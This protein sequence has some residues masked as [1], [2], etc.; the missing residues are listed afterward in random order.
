[1]TRRDLMQ[2]RMEQREERFARRG[3]GVVRP[4]AMGPEAVRRILRV[5]PE[6]AGMRLDRFVQT[7]LRA[8]SRARTQR[9]VNI[10][11]FTPD[12]VRLKNNHRV[13]AEERVVL[14]REAWDEPLPDAELPVVYEDAALLAINKP[15][16]VAVHPTARH[17]RGTVTSLLEQQRPDD[18]LTLLHR[19]DRETSGVL[20]LARTRAADRAVKVQ[21]EER[22]DVLK[23]YVAFAWG[24]PEWERL[25]CELP[26]ELD[27]G[28]R[29]RVKMRVARPGEGLVA[30]TTFEVL[31]RRT[32]AGRAYTM[33]RCTLHTGRQH[34]IRIHL[35]SLGLPVVGDKL[36]GPD[37]AMHRRAADMKLTAEDMARLELS[38]HALHAAE[39]ELDHP[40]DGRRLRIEAPLLDDMRAFWDALDARA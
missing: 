31:G 6:L 30:A 19:L 13:R 7:Q 10:G 32:R 4:E 3:E 5:P 17:H 23:R 2:I 40:D 38:R 11:A 14:W 35:A 12:G 20:L 8:T 15:P 26:L 29:N 22:K 27:P 34:Q 16:H 33:V 39:L 24:A 37:E 36:Y 25:T 21:F 18:R 28:S 9:I 1:M